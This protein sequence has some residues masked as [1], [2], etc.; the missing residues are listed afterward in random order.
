MTE[1]TVAHYKEMLENKV[2]QGSKC[3]KCGNLMLPPRII[4]N[5]CGG[6][7]MK[8]HNFIKQ[9]TIK[10]LSKIHVP[11]TQFQEKC[12]YTVSIVKLIEGPMISGVVTDD[13]KVEVGTKV[14]AIFLKQD[15]ET[16]LA[17]KPV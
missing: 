9:G 6:K 1:F 12:P 3:E 10:A 15:G 4:C 7:K 11:L 5:N 17:F 16:I 8:P 14:E 13:E 2:I